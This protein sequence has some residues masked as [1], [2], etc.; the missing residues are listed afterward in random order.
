MPV[1]MDNTDKKLLTEIQREFPLAHDPYE[2]MGRKIGTT[3]EEALNRVKRLKEEQVIRQISA[4]FDTRSLGYKSTLVAMKFPVERLDEASEII[5]SHPGVS[6]NYRRSHDYNM[7]FTIAVPPHE[8]LEAHIHKLG[9]LAGAI[10]T[11]ILPTLKL[12][13]IGVKLDMTGEGLKGEE[14]GEMYTGEKQKVG[15]KQ[16]TEKELAFINAFQEDFPMD[17]HPYQR[18]AESSG[19]SEDELMSMAKQWIE[20]GLVRRCAG[21]LHH[22]K[23]G[24]VANA[25]VVWQIPEERLK[26]VA[27]KLASYMQVSHCYQRPIYPDFKFNV[28]TMIHGKTAKD[29]EMVVSDMETKVGQFEHQYLYST[30]EYKK[31][32]LKYFTPELHQWW[33]KANGKTV[34][35]VK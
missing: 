33:T 28:Y 2:I 7:W 3:A 18:I 34:V 14:E 8:S 4:I 12:F 24:F 10:N 22:R 21:I 5:N 13:K 11:L 9:E 15:E 23:A 31:I 17:L 19:L 1:Q 29:C 6:H 26:E 20:S 30:K 32:R 27:P 16:F 25:M 35:M